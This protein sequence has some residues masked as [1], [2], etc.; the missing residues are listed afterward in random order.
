MCKVGENILPTF[1]N[2]GKQYSSYYK[3]SSQPLTH[4]LMPK[5]VFCYFLKFACNC[6]TDHWLYICNLFIHTLP[7]H[8]P[9]HR[10][11]STKSQQSRAPLAALS[12]GMLQS[13]QHQTLT[14]ALFYSLCIYQRMRT[15]WG[16][17][18]GRVYLEANTHRTGK[19]F[20]LI[21]W[22]LRKIHY[23]QVWAK[24]SIT[25]DSG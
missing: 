1:L 10:A 20:V 25:W 8:P 9:A 6:G 11:L 18:A 21:F 19:C 16:E 2:E 22:W 15:K 17:K 23:V 3:V 13:Y 4:L 12:S 7:G 5:M 14:Y 24:N